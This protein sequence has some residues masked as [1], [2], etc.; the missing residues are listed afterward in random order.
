MDAHKS[1]NFY[2]EEASAF[3]RAIL[4]IA[5]NA[6]THIPSE[7]A[8]LYIFYG[9]G[10][11]WSVDVTAHIQEDR[12]KV[13][14]AKVPQSSPY[15]VY[16]FA[17]FLGEMGGREYYIG[18]TV[19]RGDNHYRLTEFWAQLLPFLREGIPDFDAQ[20]AAI[21]RANTLECELEAFTEAIHG[22]QELGMSNEDISA[23]L[24]SALAG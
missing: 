23:H 17:T 6:L 12:D 7:P 16:R 24:A 14:T 4:V 15:A 5:Q 13:M 19:A 1:D 3:A 21:E 11:S 9:P 10:L 22:L 20:Y 18:L 8:L 2:N